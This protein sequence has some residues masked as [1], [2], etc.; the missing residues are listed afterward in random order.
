MKFHTH[1]FRVAK[2]TT[3]KSVHSASIV[4]RP[5]TEFNPHA[6]SRCRCLK[7]RCSKV[8]PACDLCVSGGHT[9]SL[10][11]QTITPTS[12]ST[13]PH[14]E[15]DAGPRSVSSEVL[16]GQ[17]RLGLSSPQNIERPAHDAVTASTFDGTYLS[18]VHAYF[19]HVHRAYPFL[20]RQEIL[21]NAKA[22]AYL[23]VWA[24]DPDS[25]VSALN[26]YLI[27]F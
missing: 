10:G 19:R 21:S 26:Q 9:C 13:S 8:P 4:H 1:R 5:S 24:D 16:P 17:D 18:Y 3:T 14:D 2:T 11:L 20:R 7:K 22:S 12:L 27:C 15:P 6:C 25:I 23:N